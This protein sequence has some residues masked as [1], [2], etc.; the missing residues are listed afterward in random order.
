MGSLA[1]KPIR[2]A[3]LIGT[4]AVGGA[5]QHLVQAATHLSRE[6]FDVRVWCL[7][8]GG[9]L[10]HVL[11]AHSIPV[12]KFGFKGLRPRKVLETVYQLYCMYRVLRDEKVDIL[13]CYLY[14]ANV[15]G[16]L[17]GRFAGVPV[18]ITSRRSLG[19]FKDRGWYYQPLENLANRFTHVITVNSR[20][21]LEDVLR[22]ERVNPNRLRLIYN[23]VDLSRFANIRPASLRNEIGAASTQKLVG[24]VANLIYY[25]GHLD[26]IEAFATVASKVP[27]AVLVL[28]GRDGGMWSAIRRS[29]EQRGLVRHVHWLGPRED[30]PAVLA[31]LDVVVLPSHEEGF[32]NAVLEAMA[33]A[34][35]IVVTAVGGNPEAIVDRLHGR[36]VAP[37]DPGALAQAICEL[38]TRPDLAQQYG[39]SA[40]RRAEAEFSLERMIVNM[41][42]MYRDVMI[43]AQ[44][45]GEAATCRRRDRR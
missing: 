45:S 33:G 9:P 1:R 12:R 30:I 25:K 40:R 4:L 10:E 8:E 27:E 15:V 24:C 32:S 20:G 13:H 22:R 21:V 7:S 35:P 14:W 36:V 44:R 41:E 29:I 43:T 38:L 2:I 5:E 42:N 26:L 17:L 18:R 28:V 16:A 19:Y 34:K 11:A 37:R 31:A 39:I 6:E 23:G 3:Y